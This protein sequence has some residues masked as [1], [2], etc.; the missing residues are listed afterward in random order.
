MADAGSYV[1]AVTRTAA[2]RV[3]TDRAPA[4]LAPADLDGV[5]DAP[6]RAIES[7]GLVALVSTVDW[8]EFG[9]EALRRNL[10]DL[11]W[12]EAVARAHHDV[13][14]GAAAAGPLV[15]LGLATICDGD[16]RAREWLGAKATTFTAALDLVEGRAEWGVKA[17]A[18]NPAANPATTVRS[19]ATTAGASE[20]PPARAGVGTA[21]LQR[22]RE[23]RRSQEETRA[24]AT[25][26]A[27]R[28]HASLGEVAHRVRLH[29]PQDPRLTGHDG[30][31]V[32]NGSYL[33][34]RAREAELATTVR[35]MAS[36][37][38]GLQLELTGP[39]AAYS[40]VDLHEENR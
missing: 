11:A 20:Q 9:E 27:E 23:G 7:A 15:P 16:D 21:Y 5:G 29:K 22:R 12:L 40:F 4:D 39:W 10:E 19:P 35:A 8:A 31:M 33:V 1:Y 24:Q 36:Q 38:P 13:V 18:A 28:V 14:D 2:D 17:Y 32:L 3:G 26:D 25:E 30:W 37:H 34:D 6:V